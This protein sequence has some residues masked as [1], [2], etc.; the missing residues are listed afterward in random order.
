MLA[1]FVG[2]ERDPGSAFVT[3]LPGSSLPLN[4]ELIIALD[5]PVDALSVTSASVTARRTDGQP[6]EYVQ[7]AVAGRIVILALVDAAL[8]AATPVEVEVHLMGLP[9]VHALRTTDQRRLARSQITRVLLEG[10]LRSTARA[11]TRLLSVNGSLLPLAGPVTSPDA[12]I[13]LQFD[14]PLDPASLNP[15]STPLLRVAQGLSLE[16]PILPAVTWQILGQTTTV[17]LTWP[18]AAGALRLDL[19][20]TQVRDLFGAR[21]EPALVLDLS[22][23]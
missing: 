17:V 20:R 10:P 8:L 18:R 6:L 15:E 16:E 5:A 22:G 14:G 1:V 2:C 12:T 21:P 23:N 7:R 4:A 9:S 11:P 19:R 3:A 13:E